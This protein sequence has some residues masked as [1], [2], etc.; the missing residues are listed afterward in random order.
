MDINHDMFI[1][2]NMSWKKKRL[3][4]SCWYCNRR[5]RTPRHLLITTLFSMREQGLACL[6][7]ELFQWHKLIKFWT[8]KLHLEKKKLL[9]CPW[10]SIH[11]LCRTTILLHI[12]VCFT[13]T[14][15]QMLHRYLAVHYPD[16][17]HASVRVQENNRFG[18]WAWEQVLRKLSLAPALTSS[19]GLEGAPAF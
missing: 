18:C 9:I 16:C 19:I 3:F 8:L 17:K 5:N 14:L 11:I 1:Y 15:A 13:H 12:C 2:S 4:Q 7:A 6:Q 10:E